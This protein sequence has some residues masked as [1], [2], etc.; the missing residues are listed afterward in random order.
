MGALYQAGTHPEI[1]V[2]LGA[3]QKCA[4]FRMHILGYPVWD[5][6]KGE[7]KD[8][9]EVFTS[10]DGKEFKSAGS[11]DFNL[12]WTE[13][14]VNFMWPDYEGLQA[15]NFL[16][17]LTVPVE[18]RYVKYSLTPQ[19]S[20]GVTQVQVLDGFKFEPFDLKLA[21][22]DPAS[23][24]KAPPKAD[25]SPSAKQ[26]KDGELPTTIGQPVKRSER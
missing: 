20:M 18:A 19:R 14:P 21:L 25:L 12:R 5:A 7:V 23:N 2:D 1:V 11:F 9:V 22:P 6:L 16:L 3:P 13:L 24:G 8:Q 10:L 15:Y 26:W 17:P 4:A